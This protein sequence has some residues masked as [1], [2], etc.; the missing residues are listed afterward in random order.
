[1]ASVNIQNWVP[2]GGSN[3]I[4]NLSTQDL[5]AYAS[6]RNNDWTLEFTSSAS[7][8]VNGTRRF[9]F[10]IPVDVYE[11][12]DSFV[13]SVRPPQYYTW[14]AATGQH[15]HYFPTVTAIRVHSDGDIQIYIETFKVSAT[16]NFAFPDGNDA[17]PDFDIFLVNQ[18]DSRRYAYLTTYFATN[19]FSGPAALS[20]TPRS[21]L[22]RGGI[23]VAYET[24]T[25]L[26]H[27]VGANH[28]NY[29]GGF[30][31]LELRSLNNLVIAYRI[32]DAVSPYT[33]ARPVTFNSPISA[34]LNAGIYGDNP[35]AVVGRNF[36]NTFGFTESLV[37]G[38]EMAEDTQTI[39]VD[40]E[41]SFMATTA[42][43]SGIATTT[44]NALNTPISVLSHLVYEDVRNRY[45]GFST[46]FSF[47][48]SIETSTSLGTTQA[49]VEITDHFD[50]SQSINGLAVEGD[51]DTGYVPAVS[52]YGN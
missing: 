18:E 36:S 44:D 33:I 20:G 45:R 35:P 6:N 14:T 9:G 3:G 32:R 52:Y 1:M 24:D 19:G 8:L 25:L 12:G 41:S 23:G 27:I 31:V 30:G 7:T 40:L 26:S 10:G 15:C 38:S 47:R 34:V 51:T 22:F 11:P 17:A 48:E 49:N 4:W 42:L 5:A 43:V 29:Y 50:V 37:T 2:S 21:I 28:V 46:S 13:R 16:P 39:G